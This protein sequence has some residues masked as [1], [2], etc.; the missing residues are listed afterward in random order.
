M[1]V[2]R[3]NNDGEHWLAHFVELPEISA[4]ATSPEMAVRE[5]QIVWEMLKVDYL[6]SGESIPLAPRLRNAA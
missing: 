3:E 1:A 2:T 4:F 5:L 6:E